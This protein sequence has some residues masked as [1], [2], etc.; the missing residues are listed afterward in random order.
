MQADEHRIGRK[1]A[2]RRIDTMERFEIYPV[3]RDDLPEVAAFLHQWP[4]L[5]N[6]AESVADIERRLHWLLIDNPAVGN[7]SIAGHCLRTRQGALQGFNLSYPAAFVNGDKR[8]LALCAGSYYVQPAARSL[9]FYLFKKYLKTP[10]YDFYFASTCNAVSSGLWNAM[11]GCPVPNSGIEYIVP[12]RMD[13][14]LAAYIAART[15]NQVAATLARVCGLGA[16][17]ILRLFTRASNKPT[18][19]PCQDW[20]KLSELFH[21][22]RSPGDITSDR[23]PALLKW[24]YG[25]GSPSHPCGVYLVSDGLGNEGWFALGDLTHGRGGPLRESVLLDVIWPRERMEFGGLFKEILRTA[26]SSADTLS[27]RWQPGLDAGALTR[28]AIPY[29]L[30][31]PRAFVSIPKSASRFPLTALDYD[32]S[33]YIAWRFQWSD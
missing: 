20:E 13:A 9:G 15:S 16:N 6:A 7:D 4:N 31:A 2:D 32:D 30:P 3:L 24:R 27:F 23:S 1:R 26:A 12:L 19:A 21:R 18:V 25:P 11:G 22:H 14:V 17:P 33:D 10:G 29:K 8:L 5:E 28:C